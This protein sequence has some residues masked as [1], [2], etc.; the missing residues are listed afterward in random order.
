MKKLFNVKYQPKKI[1]DFELD[2]NLKLL[3]K[4]MILMNN[5]SIMLIGNSG[6]GKSSLINVIS[7]MSS[8]YIP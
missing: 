2:D 4:N 1:D 7:L 6:S 3:F 5:L 8:V